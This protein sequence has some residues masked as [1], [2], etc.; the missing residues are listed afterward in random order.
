MTATRDLPSFFAGLEAWAAGQG[1]EPSTLR[2]GSHVDQVADLRE[3]QTSARVA[4]VIHGG[5]WRSGF[6]RANTAAVAAALARAGWTTWNLEYRRVGAGG[7]YPQTLD[8]VATFCRRLG[9]PA[10]VAIGHSAGAQLALWAA[11]EGFVRA[12]VALAGVC[13]LRAA[14]AALLGDGAVV[15]FLGCA[16][17]EAPDADPAQRLPLG[18]PVALV[19]GNRDDR[20][21]LEHARGFSAAAGARLAELEGADHFDVID[22]RAPGWRA[23]EAEIDAVVS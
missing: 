1:P 7:G 8:D 14:A 17:A 3:S 2:Y 4:V 10:D 5:F 6:T 11:A 18:A 19:H 12:A 23:I 16:P 13:D 20:V 9:R 15:Q 21:P 22:P